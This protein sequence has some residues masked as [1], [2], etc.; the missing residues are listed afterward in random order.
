MTPKPTHNIQA[1]KNEPTRLMEGAP[2]HPLRNTTA[3]KG[4]ALNMFMVE[5]L[6]FP[7]C[8]LIDGDL[9]RL[10]QTPARLPIRGA[11]LGYRASYSSPGSIRVV[12]QERRPDWSAHADNLQTS[13]DTIS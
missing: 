4:S 2:R 8:G 1:G 9:D 3:V 13:V 6:E 7:A 11:S 12:P 10:R 5:F